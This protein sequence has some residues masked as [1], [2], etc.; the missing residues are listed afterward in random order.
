MEPDLPAENVPNPKDSLIDS[1]L[2][3][4][5]I[6]ERSA[7][8]V[9]A[10]LGGFASE[11]AAR[12]IPSAFRSSKSYTVFIQ[13]SLDFVVHDIGGVVSHKPASAADQS[14]GLLA[15]QSVG[16]MIDFAGM[17]TLHMSPMTILAIISDVAYG[18]STYMRQLSEELK[19]KGLIDQE[20]TID[21]VTDLIDA[22]QATSV[23]GADAFNAPPINLDALQQTIDKTRAAL[24]RIDPTTTI[25]QAEIKRMW[26]E[27]E[28]AA[29]KADASVFDVATTMTMFS[30]N[31]LT[32]VSQGALSSVV[33]A[34]N[35]IDQHILGHYA[36]ALTEIQVRGLW[37]TLATSSKPYLEAIW[38][39][40]DETKST[41]TQDLLNGTLIGNAWNGLSRWWQGTGK[42]EAAAI[43]IVANDA[44][45][46]DKS[47]ADEKTAAD[48]KPADDEKPVIDEKP[49]TG[50]SLP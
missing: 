17:A 23:Q 29:T 9:S 42:T 16:G 43:D 4:L 15:R 28:T 6:P 46:V 20:S 38:N 18:S 32:L 2:F 14:E 3:G 45:P 26:Q 22:L 34:G 37:T 30:M 27:M 21:H 12:L 35:M 11:S 40:F 24:N 25:P 31:R 5:S 10:L 44:A 1:L 8:T 48:E 33:V 19:R 13:Q 7:R 41:L 36:D 39:N 47:A 49:V 50:E